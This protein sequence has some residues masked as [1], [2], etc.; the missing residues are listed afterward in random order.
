[1]MMSHHPPVDHPKFTTQISILAFVPPFK[2]FGKL[3]SAK[4]AKSS[5]FAYPCVDR[6]HFV[7]L[8][9]T[10]MKPLRPLGGNINKLIIITVNSIMI[11]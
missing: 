1:M 11:C 5:L 2:G 9:P 3:F 7:G 8:G 6:T 10:G 4:F